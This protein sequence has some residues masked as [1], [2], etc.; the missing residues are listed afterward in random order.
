MA[1]RP[2][3]LALVSL[4]AGQK[5]AD[6]FRAPIRAVLALFPSLKYTL[7][8]LDVLEPEAYVAANAITSFLLGILVCG[9]TFGVLMINKQPAPNA[10]LLA[11]A[12]GLST[13]LAI[14]LFNIFYPGI[15]TRT[16]AGRMDR[17]L[18]FALKDLLVQ[19]ESGIPLYEAMVNIARS[20]YDLVSMEFSAAVREISAGTSE[21]VALQ[22]MA[23]KTKSDYFRKALWQLISSLES[24]ASLGPALR[25]VIETLESHQRK[26]IKD[27]SG[28]LNFVVLIYML[29]AA[30]IPSMGITFL[31]IL[32]AF[33]GAGINEITLLEVVAA[34]LLLQIVLIGYMKSGRPAVYE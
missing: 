8:A 11:I 25:S 27:Y 10:P 6:R 23:L 12:S 17:D 32:S 7:R 5:I 33:G 1:V 24:G 18:S 16:F 20:D 15:R 22:K 19:V 31:I 30:A 13:L 9:A 14:F 26:S 4:G 3:P 2:S 29:S 28:S 21:S 34:S